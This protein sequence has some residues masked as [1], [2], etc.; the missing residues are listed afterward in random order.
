[1]LIREESCTWQLYNKVVHIYNNNI[2]PPYGHGHFLPSIDQAEQLLT[3]NNKLLAPWLSFFFLMVSLRTSWILTILLMSISTIMK[4]LVGELAEKFGRRL[5]FTAIGIGD[6]EQLETL[7][8][9]VEQAKDFGAL[10]EL[11]LP[12]MTSSAIGSVFTS[13]ATS[14]TKTQTEM[15]D[16]VTLKQ[17]SVRLVQRESRTMANATLHE[18][19]S[20]DFWIYSADQIER[21]VYTEWF[22]G[23]KLVKPAAASK[24]AFCC[25]G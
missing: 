14:I 22:E 10:A 19:S 8:L 25:N 6:K 16:L 3:R 2:Y 9:M 18:V 20:Q 1:V 15:T 5:T 13:V 24:S 17:M 11:K 12:S 7:D 21:L 4:S 23:R